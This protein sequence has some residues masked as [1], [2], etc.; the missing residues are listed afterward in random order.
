LDEI[1]QKR[2]LLLLPY[3][4]MR[5]ETRAEAI[6]RDDNRTAQLIVECLDLRAR[7]ETETVGTGDA[8]LYEQLVELIIMVS[9]HMLATQDALRKKVK[10]AMG[11][12]VLELM[13]ER[14][15][16]LE[17]EAKQQG[18]EQGLEQGI[19]Q[20]IEQGLEQGLEQGIEQGLEQGR[21][22]GLEQGLDQAVAGLAQQLR[23]R[24]VSE[25]LLQTSIAAFQQEWADAQRNE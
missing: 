17:R 9:D 7:L 21:E 5:Y 10:R 13:R 19:E 22:L 8:L 20:G 1:F 18:F 16:R 23:E 25:E 2:L 12:E 14:A 6:A 11:G 24:G 4:L 15:E 3:Y